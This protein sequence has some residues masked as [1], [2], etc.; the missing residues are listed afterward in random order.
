MTMMRR[1]RRTGNRKQ[2]PYDGVRLAGR[3]SKAC[4]FTV[5]IRRCSEVVCEGSLAKGIKAK[6]REAFHDHC[7]SDV[8]LRSE[9]MQNPSAA[10]SYSRALTTI[11][12]CLVRLLLGWTALGV[13]TSQNT[14]IRTS[15]APVGAC[16]SSYAFP[17][18][19][20]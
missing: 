9:S 16:T 11:S 14:R 20:S 4:T 10:L 5:R 6:S 13:A 8:G 12:S 18:E 2:T 15:T 7:T 1:R 17:T 19:R 3:C